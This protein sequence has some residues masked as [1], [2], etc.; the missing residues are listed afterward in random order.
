MPSFSVGT[1]ND[2]DTGQY[3]ATVDF[4]ET[5]TA[6]PAS[7][8]PKDQIVITW[9]FG[10]NEDGDPITK[11]QYINEPQALTPKAKLY[12]VF[13]AVLC[14]GKPLEKGVEYDTDLL[15]GKSAMVFWGDYIG[16]DGTTKQKVLSVNPVK[17]SGAIKRKVSTE[18]I[19]P[20]AA[21]DDI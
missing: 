20:D 17:K 15:L 8:F 4:I 3:E 9:A 19:D 10:E 12:Q 1:A 5:Q 14:G 16:E 7:R 11:R 21:L 2:L 13:S 6:D 18:Q